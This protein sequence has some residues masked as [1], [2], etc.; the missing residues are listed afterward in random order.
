[1]NFLMS[2]TLL[3]SRGH[4]STSVITHS[5]TSL[6]RC[7]SSSSATV[8]LLLAWRL[9]V[10]YTSSCC[11]RTKHVSRV[12]QD[13]WCFTG[14]RADISWTSPHRTSERKQNLHELDPQLWHKPRVLRQRWPSQSWWGQQLHPMCSYWA[15]GLSSVV[16][17]SYLWMGS[18]E[19]KWKHNNNGQTQDQECLFLHK[20][21]CRTVKLYKYHNVKKMISCH[22]QRNWLFSFTPCIIWNDAL[23]FLPA[24]HQGLF[25]TRAASPPPL[26]NQSRLCPEAGGGAYLQRRK[27]SQTVECH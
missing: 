11:R 22:E 21:Y 17:L 5:W 25:C 4:S 23:I 19:G 3:Q 20:Y 10:K 26:K 9:K 12:L 1:M 7:S 18:E 24:L 2:W 15:C 14:H 16:A 8:W 27:I 6:Q 13:A